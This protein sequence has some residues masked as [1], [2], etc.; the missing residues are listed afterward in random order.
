MHSNGADICILK[1]N[2]QN[3]NPLL[4]LQIGSIKGINI[5]AERHNMKVVHQSSEGELDIDI[6]YQYAKTLDHSHSLS[7]LKYLLSDPKLNEDLQNSL[8]ENFATG[9]NLYFIKKKN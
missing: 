4:I 2:S 5:L 1:E 9:Y 7:G 6:I 8:K 3:V